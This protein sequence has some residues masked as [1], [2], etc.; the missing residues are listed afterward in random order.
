MDKPK[1]NQ[2][3]SIKINGDGRSILKNTEEEITSQQFAATLESDDEDEFKWI[4]PDEDDEEIKAYTPPKKTNT[5]PNSLYKEF[6][7]SLQKP[8][9]N[10]VLPSIFFTTILAILIGT[11]FG[12]MMWR[13]VIVDSA[14]EVDT[15]QVVNQQPE[16][17]EVTGADLAQI[18]LPAIMS[19]IIQGGVFSTKE[20]AHNEADVLSQKGV[21]VKVIEMDGKTYLFLGLADNLANAKI[22]GA[23]LQ[24]KGVEIYAKEAYFGGGTVTSLQAEERKLLEL[25]PA[26][27]ENLVAASASLAISKTIPSTIQS[28]LTTQLAEWN[29]IAE[30]RIT[31]ETIQQLKRELDYAFA[32]I[33][34]FQQTAEQKLVV[35]IQEHLLNYL[36]LYHII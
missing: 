28:T 36:A 27:Y 24:N 35:E 22:I 29:K 13:M 7:R 16:T 1:N 20:A 14:I 32:K 15:T 5:S 33:N 21:P 9:R 31:I 17:E 12:I 2:T 26:I 19:P 25:I 4:F 30:D 8:G 11:S 18:E 10:R 23:Q 34:T 3:I 6:K